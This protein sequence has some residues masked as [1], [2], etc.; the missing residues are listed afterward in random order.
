MKISTKI[1]LGYAL[2]ILLLVTSLVYELSLI[3]R[4]QEINRNLSNIKT[5][6]TLYAL[7]GRDIEQLGIFA[8]RSYVVRDP[9]YF[10]QLRHNCQKM[11]ETL[12][13]IKASGPTPGERRRLE[14]LERLWERFS[15]AIADEEALL[16]MTPE[17]LDAWIPAEVETL[18]E[19]IEAALSANRESIDAE[20]KQSARAGQR[21]EQVSQMA[22]IIAL[23]LS[24][25][26]SFVV[27]RSIARSLEQLTH[28][29]RA[30]AEG[31]FSYRIDDSGDEQFSKVARD[32]NLMVSRLDQRDQLTRD[33]VSHVSHELKAPL[34][35]IQETSK[36]VR[37]GIAGPV[38]EKQK[39]LLGLSIECGD[40]LSKTI[41]SLLDLS[42]MEADALDY[43]LEKQD[44]RD[45]V[46]A[47]VAEFEVH[48]SQSNRPLKLQLPESELSVNCDRDRVIQVLTN[49]V[50]NAL[51]FSPAMSPLELRAERLKTKPASLP[52]AWADRVHEGVGGYILITVADSGRGVPDEHKE[53]IFEK[54]HQVKFGKKVAGQ[55][56]GLG[57][58][59]CRNIVQ[60]HGGAIWVED[61]SEAGSVFSVM[62]PSA[63]EQ[64]VTGDSPTGAPRELQRVQPA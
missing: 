36:L 7:Y 52:S 23:G 30:V 21:A 61:N 55:G 14:N 45:L 4:M 42:R 6:S 50:D 19:E 62:L 3:R 2:L 53:Q 29:A 64:P 33:Y 10:E 57:L 12:Q 15:G 24:C 31:R 46:K 1:I 27:V 43:E 9:Q 18:Q 8:R 40:R 37:E 49:L 13:E 26:V 11:T 38:T 25:L 63:A 56:V 5:R 35:A 39:H 22:A 59:I 47:A 17:Q 16:Q 34:A 32:F 60:A 44:V 28:G 48:F 41:R 54:F 51:K 20:V 58:V